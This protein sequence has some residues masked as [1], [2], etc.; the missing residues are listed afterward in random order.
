LPP[1]CTENYRDQEPF[2]LHEGFI[3]MPANPDR[4]AFTSTSATIVNREAGGIAG[5]REVLDRT[6]RLS[7]WTFPFA[8]T[9]RVAAR[10][11]TTAATYILADHRSVYIGE[12]GK[13]GRR[14][15][16]HAADSNKQFARDVYVVSAFDPEWFDKTSAV[17][18]QHRLIHSAKSAGLMEVRLG[19]NPQDLLLP[20]WLAGSNNGMFDAVPRLLFDAGLRAFDSNCDSQI[21]PTIAAP[22]SGPYS[23]A[24]VGDNDDNGS[25][26]IATTA[27]PDVEEFELNYFDLWARGYQFGDR[28]VVA[29]G[30]DFHNV[31]N[32][33]V[34]EIIKIRRRALL[35]KGV[36][37]S[38]RGVEDRRRFMVAIAFPSKAIAAK[39]CCG[40]HVDSSKWQPVQVRRPILLTA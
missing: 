13:C 14:L 29:A 36:L 3:I 28:F 38:I 21:M 1:P 8:A 27:P 19:A 20:R 11:M 9:N 39:I 16:E 6:T 37:K 40:A 23:D 7:V 18:L 34:R 35:D 30:S 24:E 25:M 10:L 15:L 22:G 33:S 2:D 5:V 17:Q 4:P 31:E 12:S 26:E 32:N